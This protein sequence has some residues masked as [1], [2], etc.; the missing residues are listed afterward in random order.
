M[1]FQGSNGFDESIDYDVRFDV[2]TKDMGAA[3]NLLNMIPKIPGITPKMP[4]TLNVFLKVGGTTA[5]PTVSVTKVGGVGLSA[6]DMAKQA[7]DQ[8]KQKA[9]DEAKKQLDAAKKQA[10][11]AADKA[12]K[13]AADQLKNATKGLKLPF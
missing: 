5:K 10:Q 6:G 13:E 9:T 11:D 2:P 1:N 12:A 7:V 3:T 8:L 4:E